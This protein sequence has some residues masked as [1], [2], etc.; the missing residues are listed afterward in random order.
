MDT[1]LK[2]CG[3]ELVSD[4]TLV[5]GPRDALVADISTPP[6]EQHFGA[7]PDVEIGNIE[8]RIGGSPLLKD[9]SQESRVTGHPL[10]PELK[11]LETRFRVVLLTT[12]LSVLK[13]SGLRKLSE[14]EY[15]LDFDQ[16]SEVAIVDMLPRPEIVDKASVS[17]GT[18][19]SVTATVNAKGKFD[20]Q[21]PVAGTGAG[22]AASVTSENK[23]GILANFSYTLHSIR[24]QAIGLYGKTAIWNLVA[25]GKP[26]VGDFVF[27]TTLLLDQLADSV[28]FK[29]RLSVTVSRAGLFPEKRM[30]QW[31]SYKLDTS[32]ELKDEKAS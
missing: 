12:S 32:A 29:V 3:G 11:Y 19:S 18:N 9:L 17:L 26:L 15:T 5:L 23:A 16:H 2:G 27:A 22:A 4:I 28:K 8:L 30:S 10:A 6:E 13:L 21:L 1:S 14:L 20:I 25:D 24:T 7:E 31:T